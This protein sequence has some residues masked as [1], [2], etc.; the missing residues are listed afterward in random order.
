MRRHASTHPR[1]TRCG[2]GHRCHRADP[3]RHGVPARCARRV[4]RRRSRPTTTSAWPRSRRCVRQRRQRDARTAVPA[5]VAGPRHGAGHRGTRHRRRVI[6]AR[7]A[8]AGGAAGAHGATA[9]WRSM[10]RLQNVR[11]EYARN[12]AALPTSVRA[13]Q[14]RVLLPDRPQR[15]GQVDDPEADPH[16]GAA[17]GGRGPRERLLLDE[18]PALARSRCCAARS[19]TSSR[20]SDCCRTGR[21]RRTWRSRWR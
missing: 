4:R 16:G 10:I 12:G 1:W 17:D 6:H 19:A 13:A 9:A 14:G 21:R 20:T 15:R 7:S 8:Q 18:H 5:H 2:G 3:G 11:K